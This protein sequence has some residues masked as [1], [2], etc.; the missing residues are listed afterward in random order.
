MRPKLIVLIVS[1][2]LVITG[3][4]NGLPVKTGFKLD[5]LNKRLEFLLDQPPASAQTGLAALA[6]EAGAE[7]KQSSDPKDRVAFYRVAAVAAWQAGNAG[8]SQ[9]LPLSD[10]GAASCDALPDKDHSAPRDC[11]LIRLA[12]PLA[13]QDKLAHE[14]TGYQQKVAVGGKLPPADLAPLTLIYDDLESQ[15]AKVATIRNNL[16]S[17]AVPEEF[18]DFADRQWLKIYCNAVGA[19]VLTGQ[20]EGASLDSYT[21]MARRKKVMT[22]QL[23][24]KGVPTDCRMVAATEPFKMP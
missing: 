12:A 17:L 15:F 19:W 3:C 16:A 23:E 13:V 5:E 10:A 7:A 2:S 21:A 1:F 18:K 11:S 8:E 20:V 14:V 6:T 24:S 4:V 9:V 22:E